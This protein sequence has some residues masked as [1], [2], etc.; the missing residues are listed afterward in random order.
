MTMIDQTPV[1]QIKQR[2][3]VTE[4]VQNYIRLQKA[5][6]NFRAICPFHKE[7]TPSFFVSPERQS[8]HCFGCNKGGD[9]FSFVQEIE[10][11]EFIDALRTLAQRAGV[12]LKRTQPDAYRNLRA[13]LEEVNELA[14]EFFETQ[15]A[16]SQ[17]GQAARAYLK[18]RG[19]S[20]AS[21]RNFRIG[22]APNADSALAAFL[23]SRG[24]I[25]DE[26]ITAG[27]S[28]AAGAGLRDR[29]RGRVMF[30]IIDRNGMV[31]GFSGRIFGREAGDYD[32][33]YLNTPETPLFD[34]SRTLFGLNHARLAIRE[35]NAAVLVEGQ[36]DCVMSYQAGV[37]NTVATSGTALTEHHLR[38][39]RRIAETLLV[40]FDMDAAGTDAARRG[41]DLALQESFLVRVVAVPQGKDPADFIQQD[42]LG[43]KRLVS[44][45]TQPVVGFFIS[46][47][48]KKYDP[49]SPEG[50]RK[51][52]QTVLP[53]IA[54]IGNAIEQS[55]WIEELSRVLGGRAES[56]WQ[57]LAK[58]R[59]MSTPK[60]DNESD[61][62]AGQGNVSDRRLILEEY[63][64]SALF[65]SPES[66]SAI[67]EEQ[68]FHP[69]FREIFGYLKKTSL[70]GVDTPEVSDSVKPY[71]EALAFKAESL[72]EQNIDVAQECIICVRA[73]QALELRE[74]LDALSLEIEA[75]ERARDSVRL[76]ELMGSF[77]EKMQE[78]SG[79]LN[80]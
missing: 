34:K 6:R 48:Q 31:L 57:E 35:A 39:L 33:K 49:A 11:V 69:P 24:F 45:D 20:D 51:I 41:V 18:S 72:R 13:R 9:I 55:H 8:W 25:N 78:L 73:I 21:I 38:I 43:W 64:L 79:L 80:I 22:F 53:I 40:A 68:F 66:R 47:A 74:R 27:L 10:G 32:P 19:V 75:A 28:F 12:E 23:Q 71:L 54:K 63:L 37:H 56:V 62:A 58:I 61:A 17:S 59:P 30:P 16:K 36:M 50:K 26:I 70:E 4:V 2:L 44:E 15:L 42:A 3:D 52:A 14:C 29:F 5:G 76:E 7:K 46:Q 60:E 65:L 1:D 77:R 67:S